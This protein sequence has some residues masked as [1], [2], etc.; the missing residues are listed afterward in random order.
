MDKKVKPCKAQ[1]N[2]FS[3]TSG[4]KSIEIGEYRKVS[5]QQICTVCPTQAF[6]DDL[7]CPVTYGLSLSGVGPIASVT[8]HLNVPMRN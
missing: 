6:V 1:G 2:H 8:N 5:Y 3:P 7:G 4:P